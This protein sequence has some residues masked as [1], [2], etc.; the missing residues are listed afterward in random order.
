[1]LSLSY[2][3][4][5]M[6]RYWWKDIKKALGSS[7]LHYFKPLRFLHMK[8]ID[9]CHVIQ[10][11]SK[12]INLFM[13]VNWWLSPLKSPGQTDHF[14]LGRG[15]QTAFAHSA[16]VPKNIGKRAVLHPWGALEMQICVLIDVQVQARVGSLVGPGRH[17]F[18]GP[19]GGILYEVHLVLAAECWFDGKLQ[20]GWH[21][22]HMLV[23]YSRSWNSTPFY[24]WLGY[25]K[26]NGTLLHTAWKNLWDL[27]KWKI[28]ICICVCSAVHSL[29]GETWNDSLSI[30]ISTVVCTMKV[31]KTFGLYGGQERQGKIVLRN[32][33]YNIHDTGEFIHSML[34]TFQQAL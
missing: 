17:C 19:C 2:P 23:P 33:S 10:L 30:L 1:M 12:H 11:W 5:K 22:E 34:G 31:G 8:G 16:C 18:L 21:L 15:I 28:I 4:H 32:I 26:L 13:N 24:G 9:L 14:N 27:V 20:N 25:D 6:T 7:L 3:F 29:P